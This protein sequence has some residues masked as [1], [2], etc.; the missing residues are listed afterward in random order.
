MMFGQLSNRDSLRDLTNTVSAHTN[1]AYHLG[2]GKNVT[3]SNLAKKST[4]DILCHYIIVFSNISICKDS[5]YLCNY[6]ILPYYFNLIM[7]FHLKLFTY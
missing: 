5:K 1:K 4:R 3:R 2:F 7:S 6:Q